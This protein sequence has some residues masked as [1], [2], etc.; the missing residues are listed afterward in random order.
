[1]A[2]LAIPETNN[3]KEDF[4]SQHIHYVTDANFEVEVLH[5]QPCISGLLGGVVRS[6]QDDSADSDE[7]ANEYGERLGRLI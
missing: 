1:M 6:L 7:I 4:L 5:R 2:E 3:L